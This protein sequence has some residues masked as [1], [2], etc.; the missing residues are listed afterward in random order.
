MQEP[1]EWPIAGSRSVIPL[2]GRGSAARRRPRQGP[3]RSP[4]GPGRAAALVVAFALVV[5]A[6]LGCGTALPPH[7]VVDDLDEGFSSELLEAQKSTL[8][9]L[10]PR[11]PGSP[12]DS[13]ARGYLKR[14]FELS[15]ADVRVLE[16]A[17]RRHLLAEIEGRSRDVILLV[18]AYPGL[19]SAEWIDDSGAAVLLELA[20]VFGEREL[21][22]TLEFALA[23]VSPQRG[24][25]AV[26]HARD[27]A[28]E[29]ADLGAELGHGMRDGIEARVGEPTW[30][31]I[32]S[33]ADARTSLAEAGESLARAIEG[34]GRS[35]RIR[36]VVVIDVSRSDGFRIAR[37]L[38][39]HPGFRAVFWESAADL[40]FSSTFPE[41]AAW[42]SPESLHLGFRDR[43]M[44]RVLALVE[45]EADFDRGDV[46]D[47]G[48]AV[49]EESGS[50]DAVGLV[51]L[52]A[53]G[54]LMRRFEK[55]DAFAR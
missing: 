47:L 6:A 12:L 19:E 18:A 39:S 4:S 51:S 31:R 21:A 37:D 29:D 49:S 24:D 43:G 30:T 53:L 41:G 5:C 50:L 40:G 48:A 17:G 8:D 10:F 11:L 45:A 22:Y 16:D 26:D 35:A 1:L 38:R 2:I 9:G 15:G 33:R 28:V 14:E 7:P 44:D 27:A 20:R 23:E 32:P 25:L 34:E 42:D 55:V 36:A 54:R 13:I 46:G 3:S 52:E